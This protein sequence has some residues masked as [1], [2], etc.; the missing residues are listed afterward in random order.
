MLS[1]SKQ[2][3]WMYAKQNRHDAWLQRSIIVFDA[4][5]NQFG[6]TVLAIIR[7]TGQNVSC[8]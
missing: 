2:E 8:F 5:E 3:I 6:T 4:F 7:N 1:I